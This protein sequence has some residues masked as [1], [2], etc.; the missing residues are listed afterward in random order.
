MK[1]IGYVRVSTNGQLDGYGLA[2]QEQAIRSY[3]RSNGLKVVQALREEGVSGTTPAEERPA[4][5]D[6]LRAI[7]DG[8]VGGLLVPNLDRLARELHIQEAAL[9]LIWRMKGRVFTAEG[10]EVLEDDPNDPVRR[11]MRQMRGVFSELE[12]GLI[13]KRLRDGRHAKS[14]AGGYGVG[15]PPFGFRAEGRRL[16]SEPREQEAIKLMKR[17]HK[18]GESLR[19]I[20]SALEAGGFEAKQAGT[21]GSRWHPTQVARILKRAEAA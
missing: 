16:V 14:D 4:L 11:A 10:G 12:K 1:V 20:V 19:D 21:R 2:A 9:A 18:Q 15:A 13:V 5:I 8:E 7:K 3:A 17:L 6:A